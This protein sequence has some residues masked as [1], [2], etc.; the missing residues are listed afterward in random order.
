MYLSFP[1]K[2]LGFS[3]SGMETSTWKERYQR[4]IGKDKNNCNPTQRAGRLPT[5]AIA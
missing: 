1:G 4:T 3:S 2:L 5:V